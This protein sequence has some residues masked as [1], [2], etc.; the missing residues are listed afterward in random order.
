MAGE[1][2]HGPHCKPENKCPPSHFESLYHSLGL[3]ISH[4]TM[5]FLFKKSH[6]F[7][8]MKLFHF[9]LMNFFEFSY[10]GYIHKIYIL[11]VY[12]VDGD[13]E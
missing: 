5:N 1:T 4:L 13:I 9:L 12:M 10:V 3:E 8:T 7:C 6:Y 11:H 2:F